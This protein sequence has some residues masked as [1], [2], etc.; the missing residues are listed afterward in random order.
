MNIIEKLKV[1]QLESSFSKDH[2]EFMVPAHKVY[3]KEKVFNEILEGLIDILM[4]LQSIVPT[5]K[6]TKYFVEYQNEF[7]EQY[8][9]QIKAV[10]KATGKPWEEVKS[11]LNQPPIEQEGK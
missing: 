11:I 3:E 4:K 9:L 10:E 1:K 5:S 2:Y 6:N 8:S 7:L